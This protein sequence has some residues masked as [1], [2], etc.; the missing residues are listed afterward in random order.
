M[1]QRVWLS[2]A[3]APGGET[4][5]EPT[6]QDGTPRI[7]KFENS[8]QVKDPF[9]LKG[10]TTQEIE[11]QILKLYPIDPYYI[12]MHYSASPEGVINRKFFEGKIDPSIIMVYVKL[13]LKKH[14]PLS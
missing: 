2:E 7:I 3:C 5:G 8:F 13:F 1:G 12:G 10:D 9:C 4:S 11:S 14:P 6:S